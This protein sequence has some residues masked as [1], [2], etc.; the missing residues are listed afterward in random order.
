MPSRVRS[1][2][3]RVRAHGGGGSASDG[4]G[5]T[6]RTPAPPP[7]TGSRIACRIASRKGPPGRGPV[8]PTPFW[9]RR[10]RAPERRPPVSG[11]GQRASARL[12]QEESMSITR[13]RV[14]QL[15]FASIRRAWP[16]RMS[17]TLRASVGSTDAAAGTC[18]AAMLAAASR[19]GSPSDA[20]WFPSPF[21]R[22]CSARPSF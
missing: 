14:V 15:R 22:G 4:P 11:A 20:G 1:P 16:R 9:S 19:I 13:W 12:L 17:C 8:L 7:R 6:P 18:G 10:Q 21:H 5:P 3:I 2:M